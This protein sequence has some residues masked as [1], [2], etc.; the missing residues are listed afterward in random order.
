MRGDVIQVDVD[1]VL[2]EVARAKAEGHRFVTMTCVELDAGSV[3]VLYHFDRD[4][5]L[6]HL[7][8]TVA[9]DALLPSITPVYFAAFLVEN[10]IQDLFGL[11]FHG[12][13]LDYGRTLYFDDAVRQAPFCTFTVDD[14][15]KDG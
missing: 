11:R 3:E 14:G 6:R 7:R 10:E 9:K 5:E 15:S 2:G 1:T 4:F 8:V 13:A 12:L